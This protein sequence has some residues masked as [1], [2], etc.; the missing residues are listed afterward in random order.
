VALL[1]SVQAGLAALGP[2]DV[3][4]KAAAELALKYAK[5]IDE[6]SD[7][8]D[9]QRDP[10][11]ELGPKLLQVLAALQ[12]TPAARKAAVKPDE[13]AEK[14]RSP[15]DELQRRRSERQAT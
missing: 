2:L 6:P 1:D 4:D 8:G 15:L 9:R 12:M 7:W 13:P 10:L 5:G 3:R 11:A 14:P